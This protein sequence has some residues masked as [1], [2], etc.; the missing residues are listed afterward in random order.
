[1]V[2]IVMDNMTEGASDVLQW[3]V[4]SIRPKIHFLQNLVQK[5]VLNDMGGAI[6]GQTRPEVPS[7]PCPLL[8]TN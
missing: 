8:D 4:R 2:R 3:N 5:I 1:M 6:G 7:T